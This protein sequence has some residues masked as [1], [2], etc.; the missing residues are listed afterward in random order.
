MPQ[1]EKALVAALRRAMPPGSIEI[2]DAD[3]AGGGLTATLP[4]GSRSPIDLRWAGRGYPRDV[5]AALH[6]APS[7]D[8]GVPGVQVLVVAHALSDGARAVLAERG[9]SWFSLDGAASIHIGTVWIDRD[10][11]PGS[12]DA[13]PR[14]TFRWADARADVAEVLLQI[15]ANGARW[16]DDRPR[17]ADVE[18]L[19]SL[20]GRSLG[21]VANTLAGLDSAGWTAPG[22]EPRSRAVVDA[23]GLL[24]SWATWRAGQRVRWDGFHV[25]E[26]DPEQ[27]ER[28]LFRAFGDRLVL[29]GTSVSER[30]RPTLTGHRVVTAYVDGDWDTVDALTVD[31]KMLPAASPRVRLRPAPPQVLRTTTFGDGARRASAVRVYADLLSGSDREREAAELWRAD[32]LRALG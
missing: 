8:A 3:R 28:H 5:Q 18:L 17:V 11:R 7:V 13:V 2:T 16:P 25:L 26:R 32:E 22:P 14:P 29:T 23:S 30:V 6:R 15:V 19:S 24:D 27:I 9:L 20:S 12:A 21:T 4:D 31:A 1:D 10:A